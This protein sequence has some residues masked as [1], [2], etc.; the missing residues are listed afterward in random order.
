MTAAPSLSAIVS[1]KVERA[2]GRVDVGGGLA[3]SSTG[4]I[5]RAAAVACAPVGF[6]LGGQMGK[7]GSAKQPTV[8]RRLHGNP[9]EKP[10]PVD[11]PEGVGDLWAPPI[12]FD[13]EQRERWHYALDHAPP[14]LLTG[15]DRETLVVWCV[16]CCEHAKAAAEVR[17]TG[18]VVQT[19]AGNVI[20]NPYVSVMNRQALIMLKAGGEMGFSPSA[21]ASL[22]SRGPEFPNEPPAGGGRIKGGLAGYLALKPDRLED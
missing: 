14:G 10:M 21:R 20:I 15:T 13:D 3:N 19:K 4:A 16:A 11:E 8:L 5:D 2:S 17:K 12:W 7:R 6:A 18:Q 9:S 1:A 22:G